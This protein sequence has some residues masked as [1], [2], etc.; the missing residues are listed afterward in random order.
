MKKILVCGLPRS[1]ST[2]ISKVL[3][4]NS[5]VKYLHEPDNERQ[6]LLSF[7][8]KD[9]LPRFPF[10][11]AADNSPK[12]K[13][14]FQKAYQGYYMQPYGKI[15]NIIRDL[16]GLTIDEIEQRI[17]ENNELEDHEQ[18]TVGFR[19]YLINIAVQVASYGQKVLSFQSYNYDTILLK[20]VH[21]QLALEFLMSQI[22]IN[23]VLVIFRHPASI[24]ASHLRMDNN[25]IWRPFLNKSRLLHDTLA[26]YKS[27]IQELNTPL[28]KAGAKIGAIYHILENQQDKLNFDVVT[29][30]LLCRD[31]ISGFKQLYKQL[32]LQ[33]NKQVEDYI[34]KLNAPGQGYSVKRIAER[35]INK[36]RRELSKDQIASVKRGYNIFSPEVKYEF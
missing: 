22:A 29:Y 25:D 30:E 24:V 17:K 12:Y 5:S 2:W 21:C 26:Y 14:L 3:S 34:G 8:Y 36:W 13:T 31:K 6:N 32:D 28:E 1:G 4:V 11:K 10:L 35:Q 7:V 27:D 15:S 16:F 23:K 18:K 33:W 19:E 20:S 9:T